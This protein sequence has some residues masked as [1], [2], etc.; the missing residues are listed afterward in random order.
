MQGTV[1]LIAVDFFNTGEPLYIRVATY[2]QGAYSD[3]KC[4][5]KL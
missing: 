3:W 1:S 4:L 2:A 5:F